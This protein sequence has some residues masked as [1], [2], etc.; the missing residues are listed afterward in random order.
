MLP[1]GEIFALKELVRFPLHA[2][3][4]LK[5]P[6]GDGRVVV[7]FPGFSTGDEFL[8]PLRL[9][10]NKLGYAAVG[11]GQ[12]RNRG[13]V[14]GN[15]GACIRYAE[16]KV[17]DSGS[18][19]AL[20]GWSLGGVFAREIARDRPDLVSRVITFGTPLN[21]P[22]PSVA[23]R[24]YSPE[25]L[26]EIH[27]AIDERDHTPISV[28]VTAMYS[29]ADWIVDWKACVDHRTPGVENI[30]ISST[31]VGMG[32]DPDVWKTI[33]DRLAAEPR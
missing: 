17:E 5:M 21:G 13:D 12:G 22:P 20:I 30:E 19:A 26:D 1:F 24:V 18:K 31:H 4:L 8:V 25:E 2:Q 6:R 7:V 23:D 28:P 9:G 11:W 32:I 10:L 29:R 14:A 16:A 27:T 15:L 33:A 3:R